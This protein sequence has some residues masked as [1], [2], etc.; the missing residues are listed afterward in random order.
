MLARYYFVKVYFCGKVKKKWGETKMQQQMKPATSL[1]NLRCP[2]CNSSQ[3][4]FTTPRDIG[5]AVFSMFQ[6]GAPSKNYN[7]KAKYQ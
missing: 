2:H 1:D 7:P 6:L 5:G 4:E 3:W